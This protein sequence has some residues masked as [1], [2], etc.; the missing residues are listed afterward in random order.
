MSRRPAAPEPLRPVE[1]E[2]LITLASGERHGYAIIQ[3]TAGRTDGRVRLGTGTLYRALKRLADAGLVSPAGEATAIVAAG[4]RRRTYRITPRGRA[5][6]AA[7][8]ARLVHLVEAARLAGLM[9]E[10]P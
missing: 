2:I 10:R 8:A 9:P 7:E 3:E 5:V 4:E 6:A 1:L